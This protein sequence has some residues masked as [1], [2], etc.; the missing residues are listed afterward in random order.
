VY[1]PLQSC[2]VH[3]FT[4]EQRSNI[5]LGAYDHNN[6]PSIVGFRDGQGRKS[7]VCRSQYSSSERNGE[8]MT[9]NFSN[10]KVTVEHFKD[11]GA[12]Q[13]N[14]TSSKDLSNSAVSIRFNVHG[15]ERTEVPNTPTQR[16]SQLDIPSSTLGPRFGMTEWRFETDGSS[17]LIEPKQLTS[18][19]AFMTALCSVCQK[20]RVPANRDNGAIW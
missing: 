20:Q 19:T 13:K 16:S 8:L 14:L 11:K 18:N 2:R 5:L 15:T 6:M 4:E 12:Y 3:E 10:H 17:I 7:D 1:Q 9:S